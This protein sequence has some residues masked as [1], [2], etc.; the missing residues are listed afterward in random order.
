M[1][2]IDLIKTS[3]MNRLIERFG[4]KALLKFLCPD[5]INLVKNYKTASGFWAAKEACS[6]ALGVGIGSECGFHDIQ[7][8]KTVKGAPILKFSKK[9]IDNFK[10]TDSSLSITHDGEY[11]IAVVAIESSTT[12]K[13]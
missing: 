10:I 9:I 1:I 4:E 6:K 5:E 3:R 7:I 11:A 2:G 13:I 8:E 12:N